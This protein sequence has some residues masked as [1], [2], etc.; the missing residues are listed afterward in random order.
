MC[1]LR[2]FYIVPAAEYISGAAVLLRTERAFT[3]AFS[4]L[5]ALAVFS[6]FSH[7]HPRHQR[8]IV[9]HFI[10]CPGLSHGV[11]RIWFMALK[12]VPLMPKDDQHLSVSCCVFIFFYEVTAAAAHKTPCTLELLC[13]CVYRQWFMCSWQLLINAVVLSPSFLACLGIAG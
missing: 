3:P 5:V 7:A 11:R 13:I 1:Q 8:Y 4:I 10:M 2:H 6:A 9:R 12:P